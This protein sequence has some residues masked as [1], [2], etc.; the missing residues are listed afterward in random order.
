MSSSIFGVAR[1]WLEWTAFK[2][3][4]VLGGSDASYGQQV[5]QAPNLTGRCLPRSTSH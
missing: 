2:V 3:E 1:N 4:L 5:E